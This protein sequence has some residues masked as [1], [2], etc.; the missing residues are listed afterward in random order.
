MPSCTLPICYALVLLLFAFPVLSDEDQYFSSV[1]NDSI[2]SYVCENAPSD[3]VH[4]RR[5][6]LST[7]Q[8]TFDDIEVGDIL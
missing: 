1:W 2:R 5:E 7:R 8:M 3:F 6:I 4:Q